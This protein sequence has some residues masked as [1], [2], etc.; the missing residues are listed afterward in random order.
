ML[1]GRGSHEQLSNSWQDLEGGQTERPKPTNGSTRGPTNSR[2]TARDRRGHAYRNTVDQMEREGSGG[3][4]T[5]E[6]EEEKSSS[7]NHESNNRL[8]YVY[9]QPALE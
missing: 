5:N 3:A 6:R 8:E 7:R 2:Q 9:K 4:A 1:E